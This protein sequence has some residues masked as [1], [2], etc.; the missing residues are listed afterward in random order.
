M[1]A[2]TGRRQP[3]SVRRGL[4]EPFKMHEGVPGHLKASIIGWIEGCL[5]SRGGYEDLPRTNQ[6]IAFMQMPVTTTV[7]GERRAAVLARARQDPDACLDIVDFLL[8]LGT[9]RNQMLSDLLDSGNS[10]H[11]VVDGHLEERASAEERSAYESVI[12][13]SHA[14]EASLSRLN[15][16][17][18]RLRDMSGG[19]VAYLHVRRRHDVVKERL[20]GLDQQGDARHD[21]PGHEGEAVQVGV[22]PLELE[23]RRR[24]GIHA[25]RRTAVAEPRASRERPARALGGG[26]ARCRASCDDRSGMA[27]RR[28]LE[29]TRS[30][31]RT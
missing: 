27:S 1:T 15:T 3:Y 8:G 19:V 18:P 24:S 6:V 2:T 22:C 26:G 30:V 12:A 29:A 17:P 9:G 28:S 16:F 7:W 5:S 23:H 13:W 21:D 11:S 20:H 10:V 14:S 31:R 25:G 4:R